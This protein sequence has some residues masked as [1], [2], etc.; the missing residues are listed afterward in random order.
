MKSRI[1]LIVAL[2]LCLIAAVGCGSTSGAST[3]MSELDK[4]NREIGGFQQSQITFSDGRVIRRAHH[5]NIGK[6]ITTFESLYGDR[7]IPTAELLR[8]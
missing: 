6:E 4:I 3:E 5:V 7:E 1:S 2:V 8:V